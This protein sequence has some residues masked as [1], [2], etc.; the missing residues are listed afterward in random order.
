MPPKKPI[1]ER[2]LEGSEVTGNGCRRWT[3]SHM[4][5]GYGKIGIGNKSFRVHRVAYEVWVGPIPEGLEI[6]HVRAN[7]CLY[8]DCIEPAHLE[9]VT[10]H[11]NLLRIPQPTHCP[12]GHEYT[13]ENTLLSSWKGRPFA[14]KKC[15]TCHNALCRAYRARKAQAAREATNQPDHEETPDDRR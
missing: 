15:R 5:K 8:R 10:R 3:G 12:Q 7:G 11:E 6:D 14:Q 13:P 1:E 2:L 9:A 4:Q